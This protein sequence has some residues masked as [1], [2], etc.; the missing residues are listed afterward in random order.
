[1]SRDARPVRRQTYGYRPS[2]ERGCPV[3]GI[4]SYRQL[5][6]GDTRGTFVN[7]HLAKVYVAV[8]RLRVELT[9]SR[10]ASQRPKH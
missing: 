8:K 6:L 2:R 4:P 10:F 1:M 7:E 5:L 9:T 3:T